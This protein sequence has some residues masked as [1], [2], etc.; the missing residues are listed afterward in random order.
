MVPGLLGLSYLLKKVGASSY[1]L[2]Q[3]G[4]LNNLYNQD[5]YKLWRRIVNTSDH[6]FK[7]IKQEI[8]LENHSVMFS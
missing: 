3:N 4:S 2:A 8:L 7:N 5:F 1:I 6:V